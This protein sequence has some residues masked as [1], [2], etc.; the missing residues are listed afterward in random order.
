MKEYLNT[1][2][3]GEYLGL[4]PAGLR[5]LVRDGYLET[6]NGGPL[7]HGEEFI[8]SRAEVEALLPRMPEILRRWE[9]EANFRQ[10]AGRMS[11]ERLRVERGARAVKDLKEKFF[12]SLEGMPER[13]AGLMRAS[14]YLFHLNHYAKGGEEYLYDLKGKVLQAFKNHFGESDGLQVSFVQGHEKV[15]LCGSCR[16]KAKGRGVGYAEY[17]N[18]YGGCPHCRKHQDYYSLYEFLV[19]WGEHRFVFHTPFQAGR[20][21]FAGERVIA[22][23]SRN[24]GKEGGYAFGRLVSGAEARAVGLA[25][26]IRELERFLASLEKLD[27]AEDQFQQD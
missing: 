15:Y 26:V 7:K 23:K 25:E 3:A 12:A 6:K 24:H 27:N 10:G 19:K 8:Y 4:T 9:S 13:T 16:Q 2:L 18:I 20:K 14:F 1:A 5:K 11:M 17:K 21:W 22:Q